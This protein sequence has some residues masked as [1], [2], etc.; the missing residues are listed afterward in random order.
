[1]KSRRSG[2]DGCRELGGEVFQP[3]LRC[4]STG[5]WVVFFL[6]YN[7]SMM[8]VLFPRSDTVS[9]STDWKGNNSLKRGKQRKLQIYLYSGDTS[10]S[11]KR[12]EEK[13]KRKDLASGMNTPRPR[14]PSV[15]F[16]IMISP[17]Q[18]ETEKSGASS[19]SPPTKSGTAGQ[20]DWLGWVPFKVS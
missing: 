15:A 16:M 11:Y 4:P 1:M 7:N 13:R 17:V 8:S 9:E 12:G 10:C 5:Q 19:H 20:D 14:A 3:R 2:D 6:S 18:R